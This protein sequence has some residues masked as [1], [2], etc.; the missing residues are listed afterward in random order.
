MIVYVGLVIL[1]AV[2]ALA[3]ILGT[4]PLENENRYTAGGFIQSD[5]D[6]ADLRRRLEALDVESPH[7]WESRQNAPTSHTIQ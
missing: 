3:I 1:G 5:V 2:F 7:A 6:L 4:L